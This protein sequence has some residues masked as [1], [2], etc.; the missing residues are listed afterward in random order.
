CASGR[1]NDD[2]VLSSVCDE[3]ALIDRV[4]RQPARPIQYIGANLSD[5][6]TGIVEHINAPGRRISDEQLARRVIRDTHRLRK[7]LCA[8]ARF[9][10][11][12]LARFQIEDVNQLR[13]AVGYE[14][15]IG[16]VRAQRIWAE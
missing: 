2:L 3:Q 8:Q 12:I 7:S 10:L 15:S 14:K 1:E 6:A 16:V 9:P 5:R 4:K 11:P 13:I